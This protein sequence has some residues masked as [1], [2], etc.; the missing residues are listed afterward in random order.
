MPSAAGY[1]RSLSGGRALAQ[2]TMAQR[3]REHSEAA[4]RVMA[5]QQREQ[6]LTHARSLAEGEG[7]G[8][9]IGLCEWRLYGGGLGWYIIWRVWDRASPAGAL[10]LDRF[11]LLR[12]RTSVTGHPPPTTHHPP[13]TDPS[14]ASQ[15]PRQPTSEPKRSTPRR[16]IH[17][18]P[19][20]LSLFLVRY[21][22]K[23]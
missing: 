21:G 19:Q 3:L 18:P 5:Q 20:V 22:P 4:G 23:T 1:D 15:A 17:R 10:L 8:E 7:G 6:V 2:G 12:A 11:F 14:A 16:A 13:P 9:W